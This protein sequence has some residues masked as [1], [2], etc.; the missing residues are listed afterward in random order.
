MTHHVSAKIAD[1]RS[2]ADRIGNA[3]STAA[4]L[5][6]KAVAEQAQLDAAET[7]LMFSILTVLTSGALSWTTEFVKIGLAERAA[8]R[9]AHMEKMIETEQQYGQAATEIVANL[10]VRAQKMK[11]VLPKQLSMQGLLT[12][13]IKDTVTAGLGEAFSAVGPFY[14]ATPPLAPA[15]IEPDL[16]GGKLHAQ[17]DALDA[18]AQFFLM[19]LADAIDELEGAA[20][21]HYEDCKF[22]DS[23]NKW[24]KKADELAG[25]TQLDRA[26]LTEA[27]MAKVFEKHIWAM[28]VGRLHRVIR[29]L[30]REP[31]TG[32]T[33]THVEEEW[34]R[35]R[36]PIDDRFVAL[37]IE[38][39]DETDDD[40]KTEDERLIKW[41]AKYVRKV[42]P[43]MSG[44]KG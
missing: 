43:W 42:E 17:V 14:L 21:D 28:W 20:W 9:I 18:T 4:S 27:A 6:T 12:S 44:K 38:T 22:K 36:K 8:N 30:R 10:M 16:F 23:F 1:L 39:E 2:A 5:H 3:Y 29:E 35:I 25:A 41:A 11:D 32:F 37:G 13:G 40:R 19:D 24:Q 34:D 26:G 31:M 15:D 7:Q 33:Y